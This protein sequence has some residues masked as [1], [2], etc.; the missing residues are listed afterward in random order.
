MSE[1]FYQW[2]QFPFQAKISKFTP[3]GQNNVLYKWERGVQKRLEEV[4]IKVPVATLGSAVKRFS[5]RGCAEV[6][7]TDKTHVKYIF[8]RFEID[9][10]STFGQ[11]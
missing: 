9:Y 1:F 2:P 4:V 8:R 7:K 10:I 5:G 3:S 11:W 6:Y